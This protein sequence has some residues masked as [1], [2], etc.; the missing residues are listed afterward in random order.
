MDA[1]I[2]RWIKW[3]D[4]GVFGGGF[5]FAHE[6]RF[7]LDTAAQAIHV[8]MRQVGVTHLITRNIKARDHRDDG[9]AVRAGRG[10]AGGIDV[11]RWRWNWNCISNTGW[12]LTIVDSGPAIDC[13]NRVD[14]NKNKNKIFSEQGTPP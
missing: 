14:G 3:L 13:R 7:R 2:L 4:P 1:R 5:G 11:R 6:V 10:P 9:R 12:S 8:V